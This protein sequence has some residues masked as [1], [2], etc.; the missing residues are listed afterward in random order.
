ME[1]QKL[2]EDTIY[3]GKKPIDVYIYAI[4]NEITFKDKK[5]V[6]IAARGWLISRAFEIAE[7]L[8]TKVLGGKNTVRIEAVNFKNEID[9]DKREV[10]TI[11]IVIKRIED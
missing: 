4:A 6:K 9:Q 10:P 1:K 7:K 8:R 11:E 3:I 2:D 5:E